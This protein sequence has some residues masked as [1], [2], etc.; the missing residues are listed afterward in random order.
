M[1]PREERRKKNRCV[2]KYCSERKGL[3]GPIGRMGPNVSIWQVNGLIEFVGSGTRA[4]P[5]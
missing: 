3:I 2:E 1:R 4:T 5:R